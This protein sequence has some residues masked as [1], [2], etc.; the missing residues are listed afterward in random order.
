MNLIFPVDGALEL[1]ADVAGSC[2]TLVSKGKGASLLSLESYS[3]VKND[4]AS[5]K[6]ENQTW[7]D[8][9]LFFLIG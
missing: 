5:V 2:L 8:F 1:R 7:V 6:V 3:P 9:H 4:V